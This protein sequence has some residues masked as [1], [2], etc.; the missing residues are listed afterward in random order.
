MLISIQYLRGLAALF[1]VIFHIFSIR[2]GDQGVGLF[3]IISGFIMFYL[4]DKKYNNWKD[5]FKARIIR[6]A[7]LYWIFTTLTL[8]LGIAYNPT[9]HRII[10]SYCFLSLGAVLAVGWTL[11]Y[12]F[13]FYLTCT[14]VLFIFSKKSIR[15]KY[16]AIL[17]LLILED[18]MLYFVLHNAGFPDNGHYFLFF[19]LGGIVY[20]LYSL[21]YIYINKYLIYFFLI[22]S[23]II[24]F[25]YNYGQTW[26]IVFGIGLPSALIVYFMLLLEKQY[27]IF[28]NDILLLLGNASYSLYLTH[29]IVI[30][31]LNLENK[32][33]LFIISILVGIIS[34][35]LIERPLLKLLKRKFYVT[36]N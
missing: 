29:Y 17:G 10:A 30:H 11:T 1:V 23:F 15:I 26:K 8:I 28:N 25:N 6:V 2:G 4:I 13:I 32:Y 35:K 36:H 3:F 12:E 7:P 21:K 18:I 27:G 31:A 34:Y 22:I 5:F 14:I 16:F 9:I 33:Y 19:G 24:S 20:I